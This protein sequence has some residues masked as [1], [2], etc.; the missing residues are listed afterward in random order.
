M[1]IEV[2]VLVRLRIQVREGGAGDAFDVVDR[3]LDNGDLQ[4]AVNSLAED[5]DGL[6]LTVVDA[7]VEAADDAGRSAERELGARGSRW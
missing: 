7:S 2:D 1:S 6:D 5:A 3:V 4:D